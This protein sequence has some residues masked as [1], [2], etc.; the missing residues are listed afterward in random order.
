M[1]HP[2]LPLG[3]DINV[4][5][6]GWENASDPR[7]SSWLAQEH[8][9]E[10]IQ[11]PVISALR[12][13][14]LNTTT[15]LLK[16]KEAFV[17]WD[18]WLSRQILS[19]LY[20]VHIQT[21]KDAQMYDDKLEHTLSALFEQYFPHNLSI[22]EDI[23]Q[24]APGYALEQR[25]VWYGEVMSAVVLGHLLET[26][27][28]IA[29][30]I[31]KEP[32]QW[33][34]WEL[35]EL[36]KTQVTK[37]VLEA[38][39]RGSL[40]I[41][42]GYQSVYGQSILWA[43]GRGYTD[44]M[45][46]RIA[47]WLAQRGHHPVLHIQKQVPLLSSNPKNIPNAQY[48]PHMSYNTA[49]EITG[50]RGAHAQVLNEHTISR[51]V[52]TLQVPIHVYN[53]FVEDAPKSVISSEGW[54]PGKI[55]FVDQR[56]H[57]STLTVSGFSMSAPGILHKLTDIFHKLIVSIDSITSSETEVTF[58]TYRHMTEYEKSEALRLLTTELW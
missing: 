19:H 33:K 18:A 16:A 47:V 8:S 45:A 14:P 6:I 44:K 36:L 31:I 15:E 7:T 51:E 43:Y 49:A 55:L 42:P 11:V 52:A 22:P 25:F 58:T 2:H 53:P 54:T 3:S 39:Q 24:K 26:R 12:T 50:A 29:N 48:I 40:P 13:Q 35:S 17:K 57:V 32:I 1:L 10:R 30:T 20:E 27:Y 56:D 4:I 41:V 23:T 28:Q 37:N 21:L 5:K 46:E 34:K 38:I 9:K